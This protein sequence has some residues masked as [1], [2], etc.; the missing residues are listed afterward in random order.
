MT[1]ALS[2]EEL[3]VQALQPR[4]L[5]AVNAIEGVRA[6]PNKRG[7]MPAPWGGWVEYGLCP[8]AADVIGCARGWFL[9]LEL[10]SRTGRQREEQKTFERVVRGICGGI[11]LMPR[12]E[13]EAVEG[14]LRELQLR[15][16]RAHG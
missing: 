4:V 11:Y 7:K 6:W 3:E 5:V 14:V 9:A 1:K 12:S 10:K 16:A 2:A 13:E 8:G 15:G